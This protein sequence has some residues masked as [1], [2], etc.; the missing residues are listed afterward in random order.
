MRL[1]PEPDTYNPHHWIYLLYV[2]EV[3]GRIFIVNYYI[4]FLYIYITGV[5]S[6]SANKDC[7]SRTLPN[8]N[9]Q[10]YSTDMR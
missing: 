6:I 10:N 9:I 1:N 4:K 2:Q 5:P 7:K 8:T 3:L